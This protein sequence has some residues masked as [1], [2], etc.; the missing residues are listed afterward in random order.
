MSVESPWPCTWQP[1]CCWDVLFPWFLPSSSDSAGVA[2][3]RTALVASGKEDSGE[4]YGLTQI[5]QKLN[6]Y[7]NTVSLLTPSHL[8]FIPSIVGRC[9]VS[10]RSHIVCDLLRCFFLFLLLLLWNGMYAQK[11]AKTYLCSVKDNYEHP[12]EVTLPAHPTLEVHLELYI[13]YMWQLLKYAL[14]LDKPS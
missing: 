10:M 5:F 13:S 8:Y 2:V 12:H 14:C 3:Y 6:S 4:L 9:I 11:S 7:I 1:G